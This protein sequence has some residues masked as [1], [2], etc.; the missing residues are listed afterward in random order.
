MRQSIYALILLSVAGCETS[1]RHL[2]VA[3]IGGEGCGSMDLCFEK[4]MQALKDAEE[5]YRRGGLL[6][7]AV[8]AGIVVAFAG[9]NIPDGWELCEGRAFDG[10]STNYQ[11]LFAAIGATY[12]E[13]DGRF[14]VPD[15]R[16]IFLRGVQHGA[17]RDPGS[18]N[19]GAAGGGGRADAATDSRQGDGSAGPQS[20]GGAPPAAGGGGEHQ[21]AVAEAN[22]NKN[23]PMSGEPAP[24]PSKQADAQTKRTDLRFIIKL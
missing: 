10:K 4:A 9:E 19:R 8:P 11:A 21:S 5:F 2:R 15:C 18:S 1:T 14:F 24:G 20:V 13:K 7:V 12:G 6:G 23:T 17:Q 22:T 16:E 3:P